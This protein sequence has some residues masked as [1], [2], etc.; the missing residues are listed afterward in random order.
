MKRFTDYL[1]D[2]KIVAELKGS[3]TPTKE[4]LLVAVAATGA[5]LND[6]AEKLEEL[7]EKLCKPN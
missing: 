5:M 3:P 2:A 1:D 7:E 4:E 6:I